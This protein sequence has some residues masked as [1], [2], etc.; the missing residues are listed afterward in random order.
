MVLTK[1]INANTCRFKFQ[2]IAKN[3]IVEMYMM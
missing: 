3:V 2:G 1:I